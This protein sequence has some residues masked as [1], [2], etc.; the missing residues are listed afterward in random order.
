MLHD[1]PT[2]F[3]TC[4]KQSFIELVWPR[5]VYLQGLL[6]DA[7]YVKEADCHCSVKKVMYNL[8]INIQ[9]VCSGAE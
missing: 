8:C 2:T 6:C 7:F 4:S 9:L 1:E 3:L 5:M